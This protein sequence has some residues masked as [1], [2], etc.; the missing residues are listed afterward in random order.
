MKATLKI[1]I[2]NR[3]NHIT[4]QFNSIDT[5][6]S[7]SICSLLNKIHKTLNTVN[8]YR[9]F[10]FNF[11]LFYFPPFLASASSSNQLNRSILFDVLYANNMRVS[12]SGCVSTACSNS[13]FPRFYFNKPPPATQMISMWIEFRGL[14]L[15]IISRHGKQNAVFLDFNI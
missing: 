15:T 11:R 2:E 10:K 4:K 7:I 6:R 13:I 8:K 12:S 3:I 1:K 9:N 5:L 14:P